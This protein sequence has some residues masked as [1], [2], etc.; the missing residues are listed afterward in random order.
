MDELAAR[1]HFDSAECAAT[2]DALFEL[3][4][5]CM[6]PKDIEILMPHLSKRNRGRAARLL[7]QGEIDNYFGLWEPEP[8]P[9]ELMPRVELIERLAR[10]RDAWEDATQRHMDLDDERLRV[11]SDVTLRRLLAFYYSDRSR[12]LAARRV[13]AIK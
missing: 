4:S 3:R 9:V 1:Y 13:R 7:E 2:A 8:S 11:E 6:D 10:F 5:S 12:I